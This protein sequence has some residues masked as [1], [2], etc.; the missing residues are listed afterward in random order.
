MDTSYGYGPF[1]RYIGADQGDLLI[2]EFDLATSEVHLAIGEDALQD[3]S[4]LGLLPAEL[5]PK[6]DLDE[7][8]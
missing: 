6:S 7:T 3:D 4:Q 8:V 2:A 1:I 5:P